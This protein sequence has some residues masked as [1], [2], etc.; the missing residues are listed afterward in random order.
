MVRRTTFADCTVGSSR[1]FVGFLIYFHVVPS[2]RASGLMLCLSRSNS[3]LSYLHSF[4]ILSNLLQISR[5]ES[6]LQ[7]TK[8][9][10]NSEVYLLVMKPRPPFEM[11]Q[12]KSC[13][14]CFNRLGWRLSASFPARVVNFEVR[15]V[16]CCA[17]LREWLRLLLISLILPHQIEPQY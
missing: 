15:R 14:C 8:C 13:W 17:A 9:A 5:L 4:P 7:P 1:L 6:N 11:D 2:K 16:E 10:V 3:H 12:I